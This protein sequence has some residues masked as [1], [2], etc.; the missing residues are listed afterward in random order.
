[1]QAGDRR[2][3]APGP[4]ILVRAEQESGTPQALADRRNRVMII[5]QSKGSD[6]ACTPGPYACMS[7]NRE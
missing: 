4:P 5:E 2:R 7:T 3:A 6:N 1:M